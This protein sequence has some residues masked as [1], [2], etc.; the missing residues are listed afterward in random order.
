V[1]ARVAAVEELARPL[2]DPGRPRVAIQRRRQPQVALGAHH[3]HV[4]PVA[5]LVPGDRGDDVPGAV[6]VLAVHA[7]DDV[8]DL[9]ARGLRR[10]AVLD[11]RHQ[12]PA[13]PGRAE[14]LA[15]LVVELHDLHPQPAARL[16]RGLDLHRVVSGRRLARRM[17]QGAGREEQQGQ[18]RQDTSHRKASGSSPS[19]RLE[20]AAGRLHS[21][22]S[23]NATARETQPAAAPEEMRGRAGRVAASRRAL[24]PTVDRR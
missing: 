9:D 19:R 24:P 3:V 6:H 1:P 12:H 10:R 11:A 20:R 23:A 21:E 18:G 15:Q 17:R 22:G 14:V 5:L 4:D 13:A 2:L 16:A 7:L 8:A